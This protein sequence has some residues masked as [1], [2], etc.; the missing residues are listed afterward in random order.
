MTL[1]EKQAALVE[2]VNRLG[3]CFNQYAYLVSRAAQLPEMPEEYHTEDYLV[4]GCQ[5]QVWV[6]LS[7]CE[8]GTLQIMADSDTL[9]M[10]GILELF[11]GLVEGIKP[12]DVID[13]PWDFLSQTELTAA[14]PSSRVVGIASIIRKIK[15]DAAALTEESP[16]RFI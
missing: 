11:S 4:K 8:K 2:R 1:Y 5:S 14:F 13:N 15:D 6:R 12:E 10:K 7:I 3:D 16:K 9:I